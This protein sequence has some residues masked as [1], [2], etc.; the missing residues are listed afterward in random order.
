MI[1]L[2]KKKNP[3]EWVL[4][5]TESHTDLKLCKHLLVGTFVPPF[6]VFL[7]QTDTDLSLA[8]EGYCFSLGP[9]GSTIC[10]LFISP[11]KIKLVSSCT[12]G[13]YIYFYP[14]WSPGILRERAGRARER[15]TD[16]GGRTQWG[17][18]GSVSDGKTR[19]VGNM[20]FI[21]KQP[22]NAQHQ[23]RHGW[24]PPQCIHSQ[25]ISLCGH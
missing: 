3:N 13:G 2:K 4:W 12:G 21:E 23:H 16:R 7:A 8:L 24:A 15:A 22:P 9:S 5:R 6:A 19:L 11:T 1:D 14:Q 10:V 20:S 18:M 25:R 17:E